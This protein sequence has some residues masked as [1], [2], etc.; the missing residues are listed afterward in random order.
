MNN[1]LKI[2]SNS[3]QL[4][5]DVRRL[6]RKK[7][8]WQEK[9]FIIEGSK[10]IDEAIE[11]GQKIDYLIISEEFSNQ[12]ELKDMISRIGDKTRLVELGS[13]IFEEISDTQTPQGIM[14][15]VS[16]RVRDID[17]ILIEKKKTLIFLDSLQDPGNLGTIIRTAD[18]FEIDGIIIGENTVDPYN[19]KVVRSTMGSIFRVPIYICE[20]NQIFIRTASERGYRVLSTDLN[21]SSLYLEEFSGNNIIII[22]NESQ[23][24]SEELSRL[25]DS[26]VKIP[27]P[28]QAESLN[29]G[30]AASIIMYE[31]MRS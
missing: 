18:A 3:N 8:R 31:A 14:G 13:R 7:N 15:I 10:I 26:R 21:G 12:E 11:N 6:K 30:V 25:V 20:E 2:N 19:E 23:G 5:K 17:E 4:I 28:G 9:K 16:F 27:M 24:V 1:L 22:G 29:A